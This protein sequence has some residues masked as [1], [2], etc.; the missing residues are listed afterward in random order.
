MAFVAITDGAAST[1][2]VAAFERDRRELLRHGFGF[3]GTALMA[4]SIPLLWSVR[5]AFAEAGGDGDAPVLAK[6][7]NLERV[8][9]VAYDS[10]IAGELLSPSVRGVLRR[11]RAHEQ[12][13]AETLTTS[14][15]SLGGT[16]PAPPAGPAD[17]DRVVEGLRDVRSQSDV[18]SFLIEL[19]T[20]AVAAYF[21]AQAKLSEPKLLQTS[22]SI[23]ANEGQHLVVL[24]RRAGRDPLPNAFETGEQ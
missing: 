5:S 17:V 6:A 14:L 11:F 16:P 21:D 4:S 15:T 3:G 7:I 19:E 22:A 1:A 20:A 9:V 23:M 2:E 18:L 8:T 13:H 12:Q 10:L 24:R